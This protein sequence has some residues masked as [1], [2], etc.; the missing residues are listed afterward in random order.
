MDP[1]H[2]HR[3]KYNKVVRREKRKRPLGSLKKYE[4][5]IL[6]FFLILF[7]TKAGG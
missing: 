6:L 2:P 7:V 5:V 1:N 4:L 3:L